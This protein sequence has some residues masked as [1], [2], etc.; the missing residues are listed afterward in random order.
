MEGPWSSLFDN[1]VATGALIAVALTLFVKATKP[2]RQAR[3]QVDLALVSL[4]E[5]DEFLSDVA[6]RIGWNEASAQRLR[7]AGEETL[8]SLIEPDDITVDAA[9]SGV[10]AREGPAKLIIIVHPDENLVEMEF[11]AV[12]DEENLEERLAYLSEE[13]EGA[14]G[15]EEGE[16]SLRPATPLRIVGPPPEVPRPR[17]GNRTGQRIKLRDGARILGVGTGVPLCPCVP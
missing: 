16:I 15:L 9:E 8:I 6:T 17:R 7:S 12:F 1:G 3:L 14:R 2:V 10:G 4:P 5:I 11:L 13:A